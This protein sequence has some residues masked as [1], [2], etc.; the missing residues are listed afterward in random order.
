MERQLYIFYSKYKEFT[1][2]GDKL[3]KLFWMQKE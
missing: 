3:W 1:E 2:M